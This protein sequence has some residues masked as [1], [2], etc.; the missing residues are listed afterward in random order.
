[1]TNKRQQQRLATR[2][3]S[4]DV[5]REAQ[6]GVRT[7]DVRYDD[8]AI[9]DVYSQPED[10]A[11]PQ[12]AIDRFANEGY[13]LRWVRYS[14][15]GEEDKKNIFMHTKEHGTF[16]GIDEIP[17][18]TNL[19]TIQDLSTSKGVITVGDVAVMKFPLRARAA[20]KKFF[21]DKAK[22]QM[23]GVRQRLMQDND[24]KMPISNNSSSSV[25]TGKNAEFSKD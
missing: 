12:E 18:L 19:S 8:E 10:V 14:I 4:N 16:V 22:A 1:M 24:S 3:A 11:F 13:S 17:E 7:E 15:G 5:S 20:R 6:V 25:T 23:D 21:E 9:Y 2:E